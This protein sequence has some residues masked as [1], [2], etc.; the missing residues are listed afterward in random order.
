MKEYV[1][2][3]F[4][5]VKSTAIIRCTLIVLVTFEDQTKYFKFLKAFIIDCNECQHYDVLESVLDSSQNSKTKQL[6]LLN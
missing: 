1:T 3:F 6:E 2:L 5:R 4:I